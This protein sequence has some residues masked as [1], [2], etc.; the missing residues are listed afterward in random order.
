MHVRIVIE[1]E[2]KSPER[3]RQNDPGSSRRAGKNWCSHQPEQTNI[4]RAPASVVL[5]RIRPRQRRTV[6][7]G[8]KA[9]LGPPNKT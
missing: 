7:P 1:A 6:S 8:R 9:A 3:S 2:G 5:A 4:V